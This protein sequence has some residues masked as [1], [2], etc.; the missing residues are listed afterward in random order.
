MTSMDLILT[1]MFCIPLSILIGFGITFMVYYRDIESI[2]RR[3][4]KK[5]LFD[6]LAGEK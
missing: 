6:I 3:A 2:I 4:I 1:L 5:A